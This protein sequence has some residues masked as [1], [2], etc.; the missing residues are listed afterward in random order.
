MRLPTTFARRIVYSKS[1]GAWY[2]S[3]SRN[4]IQAT[5]LGAREDGASRWNTRLITNIRGRRSDRPFKRPQDREFSSE[6][7]CLMSRDGVLSL[8][9][10]FANRR[11]GESYSLLAR[12]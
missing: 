4:A 6:F 7:F 9:H 10:H 12:G 2:K 11:H 8:F 5:P 3:P 1:Q